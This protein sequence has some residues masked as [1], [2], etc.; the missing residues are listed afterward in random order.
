MI[1][2]ANSFVRNY[3]DRLANR[4]G[5]AVSLESS[6]CVGLKGGGICR[7][8]SNVAHSFSMSSR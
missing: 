3:A 7:L 5:P 1:C 4:R 6:F 2:R 8:E